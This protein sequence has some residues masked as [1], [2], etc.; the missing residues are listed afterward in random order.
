[1]VQI[2][3]SKLW[4]TSLVDCLLLATFNL[5][6]LHPDTSLDPWTFISDTQL[7]EH[8][9]FVQNDGSSSMILC[10]RILIEFI[11]GLYVNCDFFSLISVHPTVHLDEQKL[12]QV[13][14][15]YN[16]TIRLNKIVYYPIFG[17]EESFVIKTLIQITFGPKWRSKDLMLHLGALKPI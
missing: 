8:S 13:P 6:L 3:I 10:L 7:I 16:S 2:L 17:P 4:S 12:R 1:M 5:I 14:G 11:G 9:I 15:I